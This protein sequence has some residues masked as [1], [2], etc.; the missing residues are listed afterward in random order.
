[1]RWMEKFRMDG[2]GAGVRVKSQSSMFQVQ[3]YNYQD[4]EKPD[5]ALVPVPLCKACLT[6]DRGD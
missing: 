6:A 3:D 2:D 4:V 1:M 5:S